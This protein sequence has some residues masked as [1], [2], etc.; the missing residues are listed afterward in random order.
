[1]AV[2]RIA[3]AW[4]LIVGLQLAPAAFSDGAVAQQN[5]VA[6]PQVVDASYIV[7]PGDTLTVTVWKEQDLQAPDVLV[8]PDGGLTFPLAGEIQAA[9]HTVEEIR[10]MLATRLAKYIPDPVVTVVVKKAEGSR[11][12]VVGKVNRPGDFPLYRPI[13]VMQALSMAGGAT[14]YADVNGIRVLRREGNHQEVFRFRYDDVRRGKALSQNILL[15]SGD[16]V[17]VP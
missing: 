4:L 8:R 13:D 10:Q 16:T 7:Q 12:F 15:H 5:S 14:P 6:A 17:V 9:G 1:M 3:P 11:I 2:S